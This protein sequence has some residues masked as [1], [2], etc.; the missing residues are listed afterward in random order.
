MPFE[1][2]MPVKNPKYFTSLSL[3]AAGICAGKE[4][5]VGGRGPV[6]A[7]QTHSCLGTLLT[8]SWRGQELLTLFTDVEP[9]SERG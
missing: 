3:L 5:G 2:V 6:T 4:W 9:D 8:I 1:S 7:Q